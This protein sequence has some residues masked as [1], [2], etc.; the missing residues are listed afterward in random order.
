MISIFDSVLLIILIAF[1]FVFSLFAV[2]MIYNEFILQAAIK[3]EFFLP[4]FYNM[5]EMLYFL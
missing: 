3:Y 1:I 4:F 2:Y 5:I